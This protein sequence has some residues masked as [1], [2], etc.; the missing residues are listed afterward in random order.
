MTTGGTQT[1]VK[2]R[3]QVVPGL[4]LSHSFLVPEPSWS[5]GFSLSHCR[6]ISWRHGDK[7]AGV[8]RALGSTWTI[9]SPALRKKKDGVALDF[10][11]CITQRNFFSTR[12]VSYV[13]KKA[14]CFSTCSYFFFYQRNL[15]RAAKARRPDC[16]D[17]AEINRIK[18][19]EI[20]DSCHNIVLGLG[21]SVLR[22]TCHFPRLYKAVEKKQMKR[23]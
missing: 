13:T 23:V 14:L 21:M 22:E 4:T 5:Y 6:S 9:V 20:R 3:T 18:K 11:S 8:G 1:G 15:P 17:V 2:N 16:D 12:T 19:H 7:S 10:I